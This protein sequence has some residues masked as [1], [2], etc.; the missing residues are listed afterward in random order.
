MVAALQGLNNI[1]QTR[2]QTLAQ[3]AISWMLRDS[4]IITA[5]IG[6]SNQV[7]IVDCAGA[8]QNLEFTTSELTEID[9]FANDKDLTLWAN[10]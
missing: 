7:Q 4:G 10:S 9:K 1:A 3:M 5:L 6:A 8:A 2:G